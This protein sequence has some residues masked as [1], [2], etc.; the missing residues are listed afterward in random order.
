MLNGLIGGDV[1][2]GLGGDKRKPSL[3]QV[4]L[5]CQG[6]LNIAVRTSLNFLVEKSQYRGRKDT[7]FISKPAKG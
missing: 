1:K 5:R 6:E 3:S 2:L 4:L 7:D